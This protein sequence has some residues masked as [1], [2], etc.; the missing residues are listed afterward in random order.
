MMKVL[1]RIADSLANK[2]PLQQQQQTC[3][4]K[5]TSSRLTMNPG[6]SPQLTVTFPIRFPNSVTSCVTAGLVWL[7]LMI[8]T[9]FITC[10]GLKK[11]SPTN[12]SGRPEAMAMVLMARED[13]FEA[14]MHSLLMS[15][16]SAL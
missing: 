14:N 11:C 1:H 15:G 6:V 9:S 4:R 7:V 8:S 10:T 12:L 2:K 16:P 5:G 13:V 3:A